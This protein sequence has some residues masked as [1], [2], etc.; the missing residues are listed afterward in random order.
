[1]ER[2]TTAKYFRTFLPLPNLPP[3]LRAQFYNTSM[4]LSYDC[5]TEY[6]TNTLQ[7]DSTKSDYV[8]LSDDMI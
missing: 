4:L 3:Q 8:F 2:E 7:T 5:H 6:N 1:M